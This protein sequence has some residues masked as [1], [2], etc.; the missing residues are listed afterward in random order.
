MY[1]KKNI[2][3]LSTREYSHT[4][5]IPCEISTSCVCNYKHGQKLPN[6]PVS[7]ARFL[8]ISVKIIAKFEL[9]T[10]AKNICGVAVFG[11]GWS[12]ELYIFFYLHEQKCRKTRNRYR[13][14]PLVYNS[15]NSSFLSLHFFL[16][17]IF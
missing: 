2:S 9:K 4:L 17:Y 11:A 7:F 1:E 16:Q 8:L 10:N 15:T 13:W 14:N 5:R 12:I 3:L 6:L